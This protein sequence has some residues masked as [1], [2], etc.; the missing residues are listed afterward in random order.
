[1]DATERRARAANEAAEWWV[2]LQGDVARSDRE[3][4]VDWL[5]ES[6]IHVAEMLR[7]AQTH[8]A[9]AQFRGWETI[10]TDQSSTPPDSVV[11]INGLD[12]LT[13][14]TTR[15][16][17]K[18]LRMPLAWAVAAV[19]IATLGL[20][21][22]LTY[23]TRGQ[24]FETERGERQEV[25]LSDGSVVEIDPTSRLRVR[26]ESDTRR[27]YLERGRALFRV[28]KNSRRPF[29]VL[30]QDTTVRAVGTAFA[31]EQESDSV[32]VTVAEGRVAVVPSNPSALQAI[33]EWPART[34]EHTTL[35]VGHT[36]ERDA[37]GRVPSEENPG[38]SSDTGARSSSGPTFADAIFLTANEQVKVSRSGTAEPVREVDSRRALAWA[39]GRLIFES[40]SVEHA[41]QQFNR[42]NR[43][44][45]TINDPKLA[46]RSISGVFSASDPESFVAFLQSVAA[47]RVSRTESSEITI[48]PKR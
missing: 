18:V 33:S 10:S 48:E 27:V 32:L 36:D 20:M 47:I 38:R 44:Q 12:E 26:Y 16:R 6:P 37:V 45:L 4:F 17:R 5:R 22:T 31:V 41:I 1:M 3:H 40:I 46:G 8:G 28:A 43:L 2:I 11:P 25:A 7:V 29:L 30:T 21:V 9:L 19:V 14:E 42:Y 13:S 34:H 39:E 23:R 15:H 35:A 24:V